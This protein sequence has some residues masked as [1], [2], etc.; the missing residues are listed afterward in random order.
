MWGLELIIA[1]YSFRGWPVDGVAARSHPHGEARSPTS[2]STPDSRGSVGLS[3]A[4][5]DAARCRPEAQNAQ[6]VERI[7]QASAAGR[8][9]ARLANPHFAGAGRGSAHDTFRAVIRR[10][11]RKTELGDQRADCGDKVVSGHGALSRRSAIAPVGGAGH[12]K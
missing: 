10:T 12:V 2:V 1:G 3:V 5:T 6:L 4:G 8:T 11:E 7:D 9:T